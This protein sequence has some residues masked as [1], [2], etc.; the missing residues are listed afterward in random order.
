MAV[1]NVLNV[2]R[3]LDRDVFLFC[4]ATSSVCNPETFSCFTDTSAS[5]HPEVSSPDA[6]PLNDIDIF[7]I[8][9]IYS[10]YLYI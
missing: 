5:T 6:K 1:L 2:E 7:K 3:V 8:L 4:K 10:I 9:F